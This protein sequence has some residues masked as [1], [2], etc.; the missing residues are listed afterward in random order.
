MSYHTT[1]KIDITYFSQKYCLYPQCFS[2]LCPLSVII[3]MFFGFIIIYLKSG[4]FTV[5]YCDEV[6]GFDA[7]S[8]IF[9]ILC[10]D[11][12]KFFV[13]ALMFCHVI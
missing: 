3:S 1:L 12:K 11:G 10:T 7:H 6:I 4:F 8:T 5:V 2:N 13:K 9:I